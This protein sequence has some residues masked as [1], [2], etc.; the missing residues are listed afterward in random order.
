MK[1]K[2]KFRAWDRYSKKMLYPKNFYSDSPYQFLFGFELP[3]TEGIKKAPSYRK[4][5]LEVMMWT[6]LK[7]RGNKK[8]YEGDILENEGNIW[9]VKFGQYDNEELFDDNISGNGWYIKLIRGY[10]WSKIRDL[11]DETDAEMF[12]VFGNIYENPE[13]LKEER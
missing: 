7:D 8:I 4:N 6:A 9:V 5:F 12:R 10:D 2:Y 11:A 1:N 13:I 3:I